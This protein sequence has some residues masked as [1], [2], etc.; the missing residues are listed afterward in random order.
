[1]AP[2]RPPRVIYYTAATLDGFLADDDHDLGWLLRLAP[3][4]ART[5]PAFDFATFFAGVGAMVMG[6]NTYRWVHRHEDLA[7]HPERWTDVYGATPCWV[8]S[9]QGLAPVDGA[10]IRAGH[11][12]VADALP[13]IRAAAGERDVWLL[14]GGELV[15]QVDDAGAL[16]EI[17]V[18]IAPV[19]LG[20]GKP[21][22]PRRLDQRLTL[23][24]VHTDGTFAYLA[25]D[26]RRPASPVRPC[27]EIE[28]EGRP[29]VDP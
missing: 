15:G 17:R 20:A 26:V 11:G 1:M 13:A 9:S 23:T 6:G 12:P 29:V 4:P 8:F 2:S 16:D 21:L 22:L 10:D 27:G 25:Y 7:A 28:A 14:G 3:D 19:T 5:P 18:S 24:G